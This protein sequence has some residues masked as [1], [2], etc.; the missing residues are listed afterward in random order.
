MS[1]A[2]VHYAHQSP[3]GCKALLEALHLPCAAFQTAPGKKE[4]LFQPALFWLNLIPAKPNG[5]FSTIFN[6]SRGIQSSVFWKAAVPYMNLQSRQHHTPWS[7][8]QHTPKVCFKWSRQ[9][10][11]KDLGI[12]EKKEIHGLLFNTFG[13]WALHQPVMQT[14][15][16][17]QRPIPP[18]TTLLILSRA[19]RPPANSTHPGSLIFK[20]FTNMSWQHINKWSLLPQRKAGA[21]LYTSASLLRSSFCPDTIHSNFNQTICS[22]CFVLQFK[23]STEAKDAL[24]Q[25]L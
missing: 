23:P 18:H 11:S 20:S 9:G 25:T 21:F 14:W 8:L 10:R 24:N 4:L 5:S 12:Q 16:A 1:G 22:F 7:L 13:G 2:A 15:G 17:P 6:G 19:F 3:D